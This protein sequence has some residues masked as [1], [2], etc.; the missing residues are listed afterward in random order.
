MKSK[1]HEFNNSKITFMSKNILLLLGI[2]ASH[3]AFAQD[4]ASDDFERSTGLGS[5]WT[6]YFGGNDIGIVANSD[7][8]ILNSP[9]RFGIEAWTG[10][11]FSADQYSQAVISPDKIDS[12]LTQVFVRRRTSDA[13]RYGFHWGNDNTPAEWAIKYDGVPTA[14]TRILASMLSPIPPAPGDTLRIE[15][16]TDTA[17]GYPVIK[18]FHNGNLLLTAIDSDA[19]AIQNGAPGMAFRF[20]INFPAVYPAKAFEEWNGGSLLSNPSSITENSFAN[21]GVTIYPNPVSSSSVV[22]IDSELLQQSPVLR[23][24]NLT[25]KE[26]KNLKIVNEKTPLIISNF[27]KGMYFYQLNLLNGKTINGKLMVQ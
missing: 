15:V 24:Y 10:S 13:A 26:I 7:L 8:G 21:A 16:R 27:S 25:G 20:R 19:V 9:T 5:N 22:R 14:Q 3:L 18:G 23:I 6:N 17:T 2:A 4:P 12:M 11:T 1:I